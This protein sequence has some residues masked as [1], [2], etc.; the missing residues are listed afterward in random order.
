[1]KL[2]HKMFYFTANESDAKSFAVLFPL[3]FT[4]SKWRQKGLGY[5]ETIK[6][7]SNLRRRFALSPTKP[8]L[9]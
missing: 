1:M 4:C 9:I 3:R 5:V 7:L 8:S 2:L 6:W